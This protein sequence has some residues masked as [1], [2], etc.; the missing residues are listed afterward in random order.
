MLTDCF[1]HFRNIYD[2]NDNIRSVRSQNITKF[3]EAPTTN[4][5]ISNRV[6]K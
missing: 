2:A 4:G 1:L 6:K 3:V 5:S